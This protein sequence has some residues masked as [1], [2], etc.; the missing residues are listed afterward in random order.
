MHT[1][2]MDIT[3]MVSEDCA[4]TAMRAIKTID[5]IGTVAVTYPDSRAFVE[6]EDESSVTRQV[7]DVLARAGFGVRKRDVG[8]SAKFA[9]S[10]RCGTRG[11]MD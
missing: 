2:V 8:I 10:S 5:G 7:A 11:C 3:G 1:E 9:C 4:E 6:C